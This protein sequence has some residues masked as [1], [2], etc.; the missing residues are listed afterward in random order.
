VLRTLKKP[1]GEHHSAQPPEG[2]KM[3]AT[4]VKYRRNQEVPL[5][6]ANDQ[7]VKV[8][9]VCSEC[10][11]RNYDTKKNKKNTTD[12]LELKK[13]CRFCRKHTVHRESK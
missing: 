13:Y 8:T 3:A 2:G 12:R 4:A 7:R 1:P 10:K 11:Q 5:Q 6:M 9:L